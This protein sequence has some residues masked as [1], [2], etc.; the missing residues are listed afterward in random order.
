MYVPIRPIGRGLTLS[1]V[2][3]IIVALPADAQ[4]PDFLFQRPNFTLGLYGGWSVPRE[5]SDLFDFVREEM[6]IER[7]DFSGPLF[8]GDVGVRLSERLDLALGVEWARGEQRSALWDWEEVVGDDVFLIEQTSALTT[9]R[10]NASARLYLLERGRTIGT[11]AWVPARWSPYVGG[12][13]GIVWYSFEQWGDFVDYLTVDDPEGPVIF[14][15]RF[16]SSRNG[17]AP[18]AMAGLDISLTPRVVLRGEYRYNWGSAPVDSRV[19]D[20][21]D[22]IDLSGHRAT[23]GIAMRF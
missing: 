7:G 1:F 5:S 12:G 22:P 20:G 4:R 16:R 15:D 9:T 21:F 8:G 13:A 2:F 23:I 19:F 18:H 3:L 6:T 10:L 11:H 17:V 14:T